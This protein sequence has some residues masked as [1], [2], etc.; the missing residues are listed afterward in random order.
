LCQ[1]NYEHP[2][3]RESDLFTTNGKLEN[4][5][6]KLTIFNKSLANDIRY[7]FIDN[8]DRKLKAEVVRLIKIFKTMEPNSVAKSSYIVYR[9]GNKIDTSNIITDAF[10]HSISQEVERCGIDG[11]HWTYQGYWPSDAPHIEKCPHCDNPDV[12]EPQYCICANEY[13]QY[14]FWNRGSED[15]H[16]DLSSDEEWYDF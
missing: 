9:I 1:Y 4:K 14:T 8:N 13:I 12:S 2:S 5:I 11:I 15:E 16:P 7:E 10:M 3:K 6:N